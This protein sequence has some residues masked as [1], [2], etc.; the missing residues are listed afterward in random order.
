MENSNSNTGSTNSINPEELVEALRAY[1][2]QIPDFTT[3]SGL[4]RLG[5]ISK[6]D[7]DF[8]DAAVN[9]IGLSDTL[10]Q[11]VKTTPEQCMQE[12]TDGARWSAVED[13][14]AALLSGVQKANLV[15]RHRLGLKVLQAYQITKQLVRTEAGADLVPHLAEMRRHNRLGLRRIKS[16]QP[17]MTQ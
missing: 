7:R 17:A 9:A 3:E 2:Q 15:R 11:A 12:A 8:I 1:R 13:E 16:K 14:L 6:L 5:S 10:Q 4:N